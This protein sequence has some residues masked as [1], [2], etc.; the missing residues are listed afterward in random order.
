MP[1]KER[2]RVTYLVMKDWDRLT[3]KQARAVLK[4]LATVDAD[5]VLW[6]QEK[7][8]LQTAIEKLQKA[9]ALAEDK[10]RVRRE[11][12]ETIARANDHLRRLEMILNPRSPEAAAM[13]RA[14]SGYI[15]TPPLDAQKNVRI[16]ANCAQKNVPSTTKHAE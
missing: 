8:N 11:R 12:D 9:L 13:R 10:E 15:K 1:S 14:H 3:L 2:M 6:D 16:P 4:A 7:P 5:E